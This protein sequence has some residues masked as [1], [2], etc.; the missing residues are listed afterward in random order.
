[1]FT[2]LG[3]SKTATTFVKHFSERKNMGMSE[4][5]GKIKVVKVYTPNMIW[6][7]HCSLVSETNPCRSGKKMKYF[8][9]TTFFE[10]IRRSSTKSLNV[11]F[12]LTLI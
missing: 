11:V 3:V 8:F 12:Y 1:M 7:G 5:M 2:G 9:L 6:D 10:N 4:I